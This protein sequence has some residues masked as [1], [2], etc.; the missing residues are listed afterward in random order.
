MILKKSIK[1]KE[2]DLPSP[3]QSLYGIWGTQGSE[4]ILGECSGQ[5]LHL[6]IKVQIQRRGKQTVTHTGGTEKN[7]RSA[8]RAW[9]TPEQTALGLVVGGRETALWKRW[10]LMR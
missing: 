1:Q 8:L 4:L 6:S 5:R 10:L 7:R 2:K 9:R 3:V